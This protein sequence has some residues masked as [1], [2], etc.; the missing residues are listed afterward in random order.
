MSHQF[1][2]YS[3][4]LNRSLS[5]AVDYLESLPER[6]IDKQVTSQSLRRK[7][8]GSLPQKPSNPEQVLDELVTNVESG[9]IGSG[10]PR[11]F[12]YA[13]VVPSRLLWLQT[14]W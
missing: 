11:Y 3:K 9:L 1:N 5:H 12:G 10:G 14:G 4:L 2:Q 13:S 8:G 6:P 7:I